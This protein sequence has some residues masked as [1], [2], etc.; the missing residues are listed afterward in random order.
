VA[1]ARGEV[2]VVA[3]PRILFVVPLLLAGMYLPALG[4]DPAPPPSGVLGMRHEAFDR[5]DVT[6]HCG[7]TL[8]MQ[9]DSRWVHIIGPGQDGLLVPAEG[10]PVTSR[11]L[12]QT[13]DVYTTGAW[14]TPGTYYLTCSVHPEMT[15]KVVV[16]GCCC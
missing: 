7:D 5:K 10:V 9:N 1:A 14:T 3:I 15:V 2:G 6:V 16:T 11:R 8:T 13:G 4:A 12:T